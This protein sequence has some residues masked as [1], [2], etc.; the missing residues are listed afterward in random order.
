MTA[1]LYFEDLSVGQ[2]FRSAFVE[3][4]AESIISFARENDPQY[5]HLDAEAAKDSM[6]GGLVASGWQTAA[7]S[8]RLLVEGSGVTFAGGVVGVDAHISWKRPVRPGDRLRAECEI[9]KLAESPSRRDGGF[10][11]F[12]GSTFN[13]HEKVVQNLQA[14]MLVRRRSG[15]EQ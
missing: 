7:L 8:L 14:T 15:P 13:Q 10:A 2:K 3:M 11:S 1:L 5:F 9:T 12:F 4:T 6:F